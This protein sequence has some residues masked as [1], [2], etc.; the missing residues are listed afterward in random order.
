MASLDRRAPDEN[1]I[2]GF[3]NGKNIFNVLYQG[4]HV[5]DI[6]GYPTFTSSGNGILTNG[7]DGATLQFNIAHDLGANVKSCG[8]PAGIWAYSSNNVTIQHNVSTRCRPSCRI[9]GPVADCRYG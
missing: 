7:V 3:G 1:G 4:N 8:G 2:N 5:Y 6:G 9:A